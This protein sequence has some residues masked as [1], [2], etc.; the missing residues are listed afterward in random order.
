[1]IGLEAYGTMAPR[2]KAGLCLVFLFAVAAALAPW[3]A[4]HD[5]YAQDLAMRLQPPVWSDGGDWSHP[6][7]TDGFG[8]DYLS[9][10][11]H[12]GRIS[13]SIA[14]IVVA[15]SAPIGILL[16]MAGGYF[17]GFIDNCIMFIITTRLSLPVVLVTLAIVSITGGSFMTAALVLGFLFW[18][19]FGRCNPCCNPAASQQAIHPQ[20]P[21]YRRFSPA[22][23]D[24]R[25]PAE[26]RYA[27]NGDRYD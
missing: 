20:R 7:G 17:G 10:L 15:I 3:L 4:P 12:G 21:G 9:R 23:A 6:L 8:R 14:L 13:I 2:L 18:D 27:G 19:R 16:G 25:S 1:M 11:I 5:P 26:R 24:A 22:G